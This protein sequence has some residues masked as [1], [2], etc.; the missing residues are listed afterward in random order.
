MKTIKII[1]IGEAKKLFLFAIF[2]SLG[3]GLYKI[4][5]LQLIEC[6]SFSCLLFESYGN[7]DISGVKYLFPVLIW[8]LPQVIL[9]NQFGNYIEKDLSQNAAIIFTRTYKKKDWFIGKIATLFIY[10][11]LYYIIQL[12]Y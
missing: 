11:V 12:S 9:V 6:K 2:I 8:I 4:N 3:I 10:V 7:L 5:M 1:R